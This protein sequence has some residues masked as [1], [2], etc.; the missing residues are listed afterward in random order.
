MTCPV[1]LDGGLRGSGGCAQPLDANSQ[2]FCHFPRV[3]CGEPPIPY[4]TPIRPPKPPA[5]SFADDGPRASVRVVHLR[6]TPEAA[7]WVA[8]F[9]LVIGEAVRITG[10]T[11]RRT[12]DGGL[13]ADM[14]RMGRRDPASER[15][16]R[17]LG[18]E[19]REEV[20]RQA[21]AAFTALGGE[22]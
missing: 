19:L 2:R 12:P 6:L 7:R 3:G 11:L 15:G 4:Q 20:T 18:A 13:K 17:L 21:A 5:V 22:A 10:C 1:L 16:V 9:N 8:V 14:P